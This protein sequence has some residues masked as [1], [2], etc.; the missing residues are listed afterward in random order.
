MTACS[1]DSRVVVGPTAGR[2]ARRAA[3]Y[4]AAS[5]Q[6]RTG[7][8]WPTVT[9][10][11]SRPG[12]I[13]ID[14][15]ADGGTG[16][17]EIAVVARAGSIFVRAC[18][19]AR[20]LA[21]AGLFLR[22]AILR[23]GAVEWSGSVERRPAYPVRGHTIACHQQNNT[24]DKWDLAE[25]EAYLT[26][27]SAWGDNTVVVYP[28][29]PARWRGALPFDEPRW[30]SH[31]ERA[32]EF[33]RQWEIHR[34]L[35][36][37]AHELGLRYGAWLPVNDI[38]P[39]QVARD[40]E[41]TRNGGS[42]VCPARP[43]ARA[44]IRSI[45]DRLFAAL[46]A[47]D[48]LFLPAK[49]D[50]GC[51]GCPDCTPWTPTYIEL[52]TEQLGQARAYHPECAVWLSPQGLDSAEAATLFG[53]LDR[54]RPDW[55]EA[56]AA[57]PFGETIT[58]GTGAELS[59]LE[60]RRSGPIT[61]P[62]ARVRA[63][64]P[65]DYR[66]VLYPDETHTFRSQYPIAGMDPAVRHVWGREDGPAPRPVEMAA[67]HHST[68][69]F[70]D[71]A[72]PY[73]EGDTDDLNKFVWS[74]LNTAPERSAEDIVAEYCRWFFGSA[75]ATAAAA[76]CLDLEQ[77]LGGPIVDDPRVARVLD[78]VLRCEQDNAALEQNWRWLLLRLTAQMLAHISAVQRRDREL[79]ATLRYRLASF[80]QQLDPR[81]ALSA[82]LDE[83][84][85]Q[86]A[87]TN[88]LLAELVATRDRLF[89]LHSLA[90][91]GVARLQNSYQHWDLVERDWRTVRMQLDDP[92]QLA[93]SP[94]W[95]EALNSSLQKAE[96]VQLSALTSVP[97]VN[98]LVE[99][100]WD[101]NRAPGSPAG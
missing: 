54:D 15:T 20:T 88:D 36:E 17:E 62:I 61:G 94:V 10:T 43:Q 79:S 97:I 86:L 69:P 81:P 95:R 87:S 26:E 53:W 31:A 50:G 35:P 22:T 90:V 27:L 98:A 44:I 28:L 48:I 41:L 99:A 71:G 58:F 42:Y 89:A 19:D 2:T 23:P 5:V 7:W 56:M 55:V 33:D 13:V 84:V 93:D 40:P 77:L 38:F 80:D 68:S 25:W 72:T 59:L 66:L 85:R 82:A 63:A 21:A 16:T 37:L 91:R 12:D 76:V 3:G 52:V 14:A 34:Q 67:L 9:T 46:P 11:D 83:L 74:A 32:A 57:G 96:T 8:S 75:T 70:S 65:G 100:P 101:S 6:A 24:A 29:H 39:E 49:D 47:L 64:L 92:D 51:P 60:Y 78:S 73:S 45:R 1:A 18:S 30:F 4:L